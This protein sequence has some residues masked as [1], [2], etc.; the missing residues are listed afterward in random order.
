MALAKAVRVS[1]LVPPTASFDRFLHRSSRASSEACRLAGIVAS[2]HQPRRGI[3]AAGIGQHPALDDRLGQFLDKQRH[4]VGA[5]DD[6]RGDLL[7]SRASNYSRSLPRKRLG[8]PIGREMPGVSG[9]VQIFS[10]APGACA[11]RRHTRYGRP[12]TP[13]RLPRPGAMRVYRC[14]GCPKERSWHNKSSACGE[15]TLPCNR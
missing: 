2:R 4:P 13:R 5:V 1:I 6:L 3:A 12:S 7:G 14:P 15:Q 8:F 10:A 11:A 9:L